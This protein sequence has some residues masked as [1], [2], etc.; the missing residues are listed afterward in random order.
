MCTI[1]DPRVTLTR[2]IKAI[3]FCWDCYWSLINT[4]PAAIQN[5]M[6]IRTHVTAVDHM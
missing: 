5:T 6:T 4:H 2:E 3:Q 1:V